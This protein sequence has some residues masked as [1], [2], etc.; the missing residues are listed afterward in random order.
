MR[1]SLKAML[2]IA[3]K[4]SAPIFVLIGCIHLILGVG[5][6]VLLGASL[7]PATLSDP[8]LD[9]QNRFYGVAFSV[10]GFL[11]YICANDLN[12]Y[13]TVLR[14]LIWV[15]FAAG[16]SRLVSIA[17]YGLPSVVVMVLLG[18]ELLLPPTLHLWLKH[19]L[20]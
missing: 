13:Q 10:Y 5:A 11:M 9:S 2:P 4:L 1:H 16:L 17:I 3:L 6:E 14:V 8:V 15:F 20:R 12:K 18:L 7:D 19:S